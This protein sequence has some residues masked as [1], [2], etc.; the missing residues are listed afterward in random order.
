MRTARIERRG[1]RHAAICDFQ[2]VGREENTEAS[3][4]FR[5]G[6]RADLPAQRRNC[7]PVPWNTT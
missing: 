6:W 5:Y 7:L 2:K 4:V 3:I 1:A